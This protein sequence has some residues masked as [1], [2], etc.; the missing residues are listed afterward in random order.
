MWLDLL[1]TLK[2]GDPMNNL[3]QHI[4]SRIKLYR[5]ALGMRS[6]EL[7][8]RIYKSKSTV[9][10]YENGD[11]TMDVLT[12]FDIAQALDI[13]PTKLIDYQIQDRNGQQL[14]VRRPSGFFTN[15][16]L[17]YMY[18]LD[19]Q[20]NSIVKSVI[21]LQFPSAEGEGYTAI[22]Y[23]DVADYDN[24]HTCYYYYYGDVNF[25]DLY[26]NYIFTN[27]VNPAE[28]AFIVV[29]NPLKS[30]H[31]AIALVS[32]ISNFYLVPISYR[33]IISRTIIWDEKEILN[34]LRFT[35]EELS[36]IKKKN[37]LL[38]PNARGYRST[39]KENNTKN[40]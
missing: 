24:L 5:K 21:E 40:E 14:I 29:V 16:G 37:M 26:V 19:G 39:I 11:V 34:A 9:S 25:S 35:K 20:S 6:D 38:L 2:E 28:K 27:Q 10:K 31:Q 23:N 30:G 8:K 12:L 33:A 17:Y 32:G 15:P 13:S 1:G 22:F 4:G 3:L 18:H 36:A 7:A